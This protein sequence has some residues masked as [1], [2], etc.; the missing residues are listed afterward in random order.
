MAVKTYMRNAFGKWRWVLYSV[1]LLIV[2]SL[3]GFMFILLGGRFVVDDQHFVFSESTVLETEDGDE[4]VKLYDENRTYV[5]L[6]TVPE[7]V[8][9]AF[10]AIEDHRFYEHSGV[11]I[12]AVGRAL[13]RDVTTWSKTEGAS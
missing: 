8:V 5:P 1:G 7:H 6:E 4:V 12:W 11:D 10:L 13:Y 2:L 3:L 9:D